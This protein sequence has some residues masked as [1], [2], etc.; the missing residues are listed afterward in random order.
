MSDRQD[1][2]Q[3]FGFQNHARRR[4]ISRN[5]LDLQRNNVHPERREDFAQANAAPGDRPQNLNDISLQ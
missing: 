4:L 3:E 1:L 2:G 5:L